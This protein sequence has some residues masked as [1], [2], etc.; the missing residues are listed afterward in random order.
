MRNQ[1]R[2]L[3]LCKLWIHVKTKV[4]NEPLPFLQGKGSFKYFFIFYLCIPCGY[5]WANIVLKIFT[6]VWYIS[7][8]GKP[9]TCAIGIANMN[10]QAMYNENI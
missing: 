5:K 8:W 1:V 4:N 7:N 9:I 2:V 6:K 10:M 3:R